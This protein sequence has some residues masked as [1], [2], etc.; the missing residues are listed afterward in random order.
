MIIKSKVMPES[1]KSKRHDED[2]GRCANRSTRYGSG[3]GDCLTINVS[4]QRFHCTEVSFQEFVQVDK[5]ILAMIESEGSFLEVDIKNHRLY[6]AV[7]C[8]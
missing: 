1:A 3:D 8:D 6:R 2:Q 7:G 4:A 5:K